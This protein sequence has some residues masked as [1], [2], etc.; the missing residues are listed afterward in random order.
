[1]LKR[2]VNFTPVMYKS[3]E[4]FYIIKVNLVCNCMPAP[5]YM[6]VAFFFKANQKAGRK[7]CEL[8]AF[9]TQR[10]NSILLI[11]AVQT[12]CPTNIYE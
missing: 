4:S 10:V 3:T 6:V 2:M 5:L 7:P 12:D 9:D 1:M 8:N 11:A